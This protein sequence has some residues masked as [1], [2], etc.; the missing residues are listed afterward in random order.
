MDEDQP[1]M[2]LQNHGRQGGLRKNNPCSARPQ[3]LGEAQEQGPGISEGTNK[4]MIKPQFSRVP[5][6]P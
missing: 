1:G 2:M 5:G 4:D 3:A 6:R